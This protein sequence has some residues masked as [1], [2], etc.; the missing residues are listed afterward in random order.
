MRVAVLS[1]ARSASAQGFTVRQLHAE[2][3]SCTSCPHDG[4]LSR[5][6]N[7]GRKG[8]DPC[9]ATDVHQERVVRSRSPGAAPRD[10]AGRGGCGPGEP[11][12]FAVLLLADLWLLGYHHVV[13]TYT[14]L[15]FTAEALRSN[16]FLAFDL[17]LLMTVATL[18]LAFTA[19]AWVVATAF[20]YLQ[21]FHYMRQGYGLARM[22]FRATPEGQVAGARDLATDMVIYLVPIYAIAAR[23][24]TMGD[25]FLDLPM[26]TL[27]L[28]PR[29]LPRSAG[30]RD[31]GRPVGTSKRDRL[32]ARHARP[33][34]RRLRAVARGDLPGRLHRD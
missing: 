16:R 20:L 22:Y 27:V 34:L 19:G 11:G 13:A 1:V 4:A 8:V 28:P 12:L 7:S 14:R 29:R 23:S 30:G 6:R 31:R 9:G 17:L 33:A 18:G 2:Y 24:A 26:K 5:H 32:L 10:R 21:W 3:R 25:K 15:A